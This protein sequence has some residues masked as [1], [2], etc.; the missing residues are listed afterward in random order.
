MLEGFTPTGNDE[1]DNYYK[2][3]ENENNNK[4]LSRNS[5]CVR[6]NSVAS[7]MSNPESSSFSRYK[8]VPMVALDNDTESDYMNLVAQGLANIKSIILYY[9]QNIEIF[10]ERVE[11]IPLSYAFSRIIFHLWPYPQ[12]SLDKS[13]SLSSF[14]KIVTYLNPIFNVSSSKN[15]VDFIIFLL[16]A[17]HNEDKMINN[18]NNDVMK[19]ETYKKMREYLKYLID[20]ENSIALRTFCWINQKVKHCSG[21]N[22]QSIIY[23]KFFTFDL[24]LEGYFNEAVFQNK[25]EIHILDLINFYK[26]QKKLY[27]IYCPACHQKTNFNLDSTIIIYPEVFV[28]LIR[29]TDKCLDKLVNN[30]KVIIDDNIDLIDFNDKKET[31]DLLG[32]IVYDYDEVKCKKKKNAYK[33]YYNSPVDKQLYSYMGKEIKNYDKKYLIDIWRYKMYPTVLFYQKHKDS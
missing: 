18:N 32:L 6:Q 25:D 21:C 29:L 28:L 23:Q 17:L 22:T 3:L 2:Q 13:Y 14:Q 24:N 31:Y 30:F 33:A 8:K 26:K 11:D 4:T 20:N 9:L 1:I 16:D 27:N 19:E 7:N 5:T 10:K 15:P 12:D